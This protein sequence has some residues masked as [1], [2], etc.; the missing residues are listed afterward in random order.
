MLLALSIVSGQ[1][2]ELGATAYKVFD[3]RGGSIGRIAG[4][5]W[6]L[7]DPQNFV[8]SRHARVSAAGGTFYLEDTSSNGTFIN[9]PD[10][11]ASRAAPQPLNDGDRLYIGDY[12]IIVQI[13]P[14]EPQASA[15]GLGTVD[16]L[17]ALAGTAAPPVASTN[18][19][20]AVRA[21]APQAARPAAPAAP[22]FEAIVHL[23]VQGL[24]TVLR[25]R[26]EVKNSFRLPTT[27]VKAVENNPLKFSQNAE[28]AFDNLFVK[29]NPGYL[30][31][32]D[33][34]REGFDDV[35]FHQSA[36]LAGIRAAFSA[37]LAKLHPQKL[38]ELYERKL[39]RTAVLGLG[40]KAKYWEMYRAQF[41]E[42][43]RDREAH[44]QLLFGEEFALAYNEH[45]QKLMAD[46]RL[47]KQR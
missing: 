1:S 22:D 30:G 13:I 29:H 33:A 43:D 45:L 2:G 11:A 16:P 4:N 47:R 27:S 38:E 39:K 40:N 31:P 37:M 46:A 35:A 6:V 20:E 18:P 25:S 10:Q 32:V 21:G 12:E 17:A 42:I 34:F 3:E 7:P 23:A 36:M 28:D 44:F 26:T 14:D 5:D 8:S 15:L 19:A 9:A 41:E 24:V